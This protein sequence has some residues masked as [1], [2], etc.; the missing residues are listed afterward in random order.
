M[1]FNQA[2]SRKIAMIVFIVILVLLLLVGGFYLYRYFTSKNDNTSSETVSINF[3]GLWEEDQTMQALIDEFETKNAGIEVTYAK[4]DPA[5]YKEGLKSYKESLIEFS[6]NDDPVAPDVMTFDNSWL[7]ELETYLEPIPANVYSSFDYDNVFY[8][9]AKEDCTGFTGF[10]YC[11]P[12]EY[13]GLSIY[14]NKNLL[15]NKGYTEPATSWEDLVEQA[16]NLTQY[17]SDGSIL[18]SG[19]AFGMGS[20]VS[21]SADI[22]SLLLLQ[23]GQEV[24]VKEEGTTKHTVSIDDSVGEEVFRFYTDATTSYKIWDDTLPIDKQ[25]FIDGK[26][27]MVLAP[28]WYAFN[29]EESNPNLDYGMTTLP[30]LGNIQGDRIDWANYWVYG[31]SKNSPY[32]TQ[33]WE[34]VKFLSQ[35]EQYRKLNE[36]AVTVRTDRIYGR[37]FP[38]KEMAEEMTSVDF[39]SVFAQMVPSAKSIYVGNEMEYNKAIVDA[40]DSISAS[41][42]SESATNA[43]ANFKTQFASILENY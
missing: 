3:W 16:K 12:I 15:Q 31:V 2:N 28:S 41:G 18:I 29:I 21:H 27:A 6:R 30:Q 7:P 8:P 20:N 38:R 42:Q 22:I 25:L 14:Y 11:V 37:I 40:L 9:H 23:R 10:L 5:T 19:L 35:P 1:E 33:A 34:F 24:S 4:K 39:M 36:T 32:K 26:L 43:F 17:N 13:E